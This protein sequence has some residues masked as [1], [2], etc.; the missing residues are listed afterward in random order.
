[1]KSDF[2]VDDTI[3][4]MKSVP[5]FS[6]GY[7]S[8]DSIS[9]YYLGARISKEEIARITKAVGAMGIEP[10]NTRIRKI[11]DNGLSIFEVLQASIETDGKVE[12]V[13]SDAPNEEIRLIH[14][15]H[16]IELGKICSQ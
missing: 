9:N 6:L 8:D 13:K 16:A 3:K 7:P 11:E 15:D 12:T 5:P 10:E 2:P 14:G 4:A 1:M